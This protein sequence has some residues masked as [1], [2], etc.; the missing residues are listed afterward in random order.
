MAGILAFLVS[1]TLSFAQNMENI[2]EKLKEASV[3]VADILYANE[4]VEVHVRYDVELA[5]AMWK[6][7]FDQ[8]KIFNALAPAFPNAKLARIHCRAKEED[9][10]EMEMD[11]PVLRDFVNGKISEDSFYE[12][13]RGKPLINFE[14]RLPGERV[15]GVLPGED[16]DLFMD[17]STGELTEGGSL[18]EGGPIGSSG[19]ELGSLSQEE[20]TGLGGGGGGSGGV[21][22]F[23]SGPNW[24]VLV[25]VF[26]AIGGLILIGAILVLRRGSLSAQAK[27][28]ATLEIIYEDGGRKEVKIG[29]EG[30]TIGR[31]ET[32][33]LR[34][35]DPGVSTLH[36]EIA[37]ESRSFILRD[38][39]SVNGTSV[40]GEK[41]LEKT[42]YAGDRIQLGSTT[43][44]LK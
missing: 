7:E 20:E 12:K 24:P 29:R 3:P 37:I 44:I 15:D 42:L 32:N 27:V 22:S 21:L 31:G 38:L 16:Q 25:L 6:L 8:L 41:V 17:I 1:G 28:E 43:L 10:L 33:G 35:N 23:S 40:N 4:T 11:F 2:L 5:H 39:G 13:L 18:T 9:I 36:A 34:L 30:V 26:F 19:Q 14:E